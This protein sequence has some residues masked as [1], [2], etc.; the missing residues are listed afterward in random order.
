MGALW[1][2]R[3]ATKSES[4]SLLSQEVSLAHFLDQRLPNLVDAGNVLVDPVQHRGVLLLAVGVPG[5]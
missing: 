5:T 4:L 3:L 2:C 1:S